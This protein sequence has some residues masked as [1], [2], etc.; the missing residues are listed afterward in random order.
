M[1]VRS[2]KLLRDFKG[3][4]RASLPLHPL[5]KAL[6]VVVALN[7]CSLPWMLGGMRPWAQFI[8]LGLSMLAFGIALIPR[9]YDGDLAHGEAYNLYPHRKLLRWPLYWCGL[10]FLGY[11][12]IQALNPAYQFVQLESGWGMR[13]IA[14]IGWLPT[15]MRTPFDMMNPWRQ[16]MIW[17]IPFLLVSAVWIGFTRRKTITALLT[18]MVL[19]AALIA[20]VGI[21]ARYSQ[22]EK[23]LWLVDGIVD[24]SFGSFIYK[25]HAGGFFLLMVGVSVALAFWH[26]HLARQSLRRSSPTGL[27]VLLALLLAAAVLVSYSRGAILILAGF[28]TLA[29]LATLVMSIRSGATRQAPLRLAG[30]VCLI[31]AFVAASGYLATSTRTLERIER[32][33]QDSRSERS[34]FLRKYAWEAGL[35]MANDRKLTGWGAGGFRFLFPAYQKNY[36]KIVWLR[37]RI[38]RDFMF[39]E[40]VH[41][42]YLQVLIET[43][44]LGFGILGMGFLLYLESFFRGRGFSHGFAAAL[45]AAAALIM[46]HATIDFPLQ[47]PAI[48]TSWA[49]I[50]VMALLV[51]NQNRGSRRSRSHRGAARNAG[52]TDDTTLSPG[53]AGSGQVPIVNH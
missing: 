21:A 35:E 18:T 31:V 7:V 23:V 38:Q 49:V 33:T 14:H 26:H 4:L 46:I 30:L 36:P 47:N 15:G 24:Y 50:L 2:D 10:V 20:V 44:R 12:L 13:K 3:D 34:V 53:T 52:Y 6:L 8:S 16:M 40:H 32:L 41:N 37:W 51:A 48:L 22:P 27:F 45:L 19:N 42:D 39:W 43:G 28:L 17:L 11:V 1:P 5:E 9:I 25:N 29:I